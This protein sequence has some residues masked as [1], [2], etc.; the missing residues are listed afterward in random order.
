[1][2]FL[3]ALADNRQPNSLATRYRRERFKIFQGLLEGLPRPL[4]IL[5]IGGTEQFW[6]SM[7][8]TQGDALSITLLNV[9][10]EPVTLPNVQSIAGDARDL[11]SYAA[12]SVDIVF[13]NS[14]IEHLGTLADEKRMA[15]EIRRVAKRYFVQTPN[16]Y[17]P[18]E[19]H[20]LFPF[21]AI[22]PIRVR[23]WIATWWR[24]GWYSR[25][26]RPEAA[27]AEVEAIRLLTLAEVRKLFPDAT[28]HVERCCG[29]AKSFIAYSG[30]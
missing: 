5:D 11:S 13:S 25:I 9:T 20:F 24:P 1:M 3:R 10:A 16:R 15:D 17:F 27:R 14:T 21:F 2:P 29:L 12:G 30:W 8:L 7:S 18:L 6:E 28:L 22:L 23:A 19:P 26:G 4:A